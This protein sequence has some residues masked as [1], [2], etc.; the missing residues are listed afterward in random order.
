[1]KV[2]ILFEYE[3]AL[4]VFSSLEKAKDFCEQLPSIPLYRIRS[5]DLD[6]PED[7]YGE[8]EWTNA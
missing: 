1:M 8:I 7:L 6:N 3:D 5:F 4:A 2:Y